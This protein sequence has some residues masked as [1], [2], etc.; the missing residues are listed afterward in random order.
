LLKLEIPFG[1]AFDKRGVSL[2]KNAVRVRLSVCGQP[3]RAA[4]YSGRAAYEDLKELREHHYRVAT[5][6]G[7]YAPIAIPLSRII[8]VAAE[9]I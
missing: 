5:L 9:F 8:H 6:R 4:P 1:H 3:S 7:R 2:P